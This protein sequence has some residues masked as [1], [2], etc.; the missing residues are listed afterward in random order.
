MQRY[1][2]YLAPLLDQ[3]VHDGAAGI[4]VFA[5]GLDLSRF[6]LGQEP[7]HS[8]FVA[9]NQSPV[10]ERLHVPS[11]ARWGAK[12]GINIR[13]PGFTI[14]NMLRGCVSTIRAIAMPVAPINY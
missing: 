7:E 13:S 4:I 3:Q 11:G 9:V 14:S 12:L 10:H 5:V 6:D 2:S 1:S 8:L